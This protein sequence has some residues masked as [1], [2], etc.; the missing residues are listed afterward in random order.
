MALSLRRPTNCLPALAVLLASGWRWRGLLGA[1]AGGALFM[2]PLTALAF[3][4]QPG[5]GGTYELLLTALLGGAGLGPHLL[6]SSGPSPH[7]P[8]PVPV[9]ALRTRLLPPPRR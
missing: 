1:V 8:P 3:L 7:A 4:V 6:A 5:W 2:V 9:P